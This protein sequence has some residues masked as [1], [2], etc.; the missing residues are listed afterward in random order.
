PIGLLLQLDS[1]HYCRCPPPGSGIAAATGTADFT[2]TATDSGID[3]RRREHNP[4]RLYVSNLL[5]NLVKALPEVGVEY[6]PGRGLSQTFP[7]ERHRTHCVKFP[8]PALFAA[9]T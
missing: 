3:N 8:N 2:A 5:R 6:I 1:I 9:H 7:A 4:V